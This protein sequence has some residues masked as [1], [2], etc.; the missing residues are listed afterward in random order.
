VFSASSPLRRACWTGLTFML[1]A[2]VAA[3]TSARA[4]EAGNL[5]DTLAQ[6]QFMLSADVRCGFL[7]PAR[8][9][10][11]GA[12]VL[13]NRNEA[14]RQGVGGNRI[15]DALKRAND[16]GQRAN[17]GN[18]TLKNQAYK[19]NDAFRSFSQQLRYELKG[20][21]SVWHIDRAY[22]DDENWRLVQTFNAGDKRFAFGL[23]GT[24]WAKT[25]S[26]MAQLPADEQPYSARLIV[27]H[28]GLGPVRAFDTNA[29]QVSKALPFG[30][31]EASADTFL[32]SGHSTPNRVLVKLP[33][34]VAAG[35][36]F[37]VAE[38]PRATERFDFPSSA[39]RAIGALDPRDDVLVAFDYGDT[40]LYV[41]FEAGDF[42]P[43]M[44]ISNLPS[45]YTHNR[46][47]S[48]N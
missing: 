24:Q 19:V 28:A 32:A 15:Y 1:A 11:L 22:G 36:S 20:Q 8:R 33:G 14:I 18:E 45:P 30:F 5:L 46:A 23:Y 43:G 21:R 42:I 26:V 47:H 27:R 12:G 7:E 39:L 16:L 2:F 4:D 6:R 37:K 34:T 29:A 3:T 13:Q 48:A 35:L 40:S 9:E 38:K 17:C 25:L 31:D 10:A 44:I 41:R